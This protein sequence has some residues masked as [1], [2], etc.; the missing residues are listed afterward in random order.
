MAD[1]PEQYVEEPEDLALRGGARR[2][3]TTDGRTIAEAPVAVP[4]DGTEIGVVVALPKGGPISVAVRDDV[5]IP[6]VDPETG[7]V[8][9]IDLFVRNLEAL[10]I[11]GDAALVLAFLE[12][13][14]AAARDPYESN[15]T[16]VQED[17]QDDEGENE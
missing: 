6:Y 3:T 7:K 10:R 5:T 9:T 11:S 2:I 12:N 13:L 1:K 16:I 4:L 15:P 8:E 14:L 17:E